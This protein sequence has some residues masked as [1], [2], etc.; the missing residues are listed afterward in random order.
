MLC[1]FCIYIILVMCHCLSKCEQ[2]QGPYSFALLF[3]SWQCRGSSFR[4]ILTKKKKEKIAEIRF[5]C[6][7]V[8]LF[9]DL[10]HHLVVMHV[11][12]HTG[13]IITDITRGQ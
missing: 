13:A 4:V 3:L 1:T 11:L 8:Q 7:S 5:L 6:C 10:F 2:I 9:L 12:L